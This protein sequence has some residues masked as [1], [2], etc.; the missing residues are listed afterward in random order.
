[1]AGGR[2]RRRVVPLNMGSWRA[3][4]GRFWARPRACLW[5]PGLRRA[6]S[7]RPAVAAAT[8]TS[9]LRQDPS[10]RSSAR[11]ARKCRPCRLLSGPR[12]AGPVRS[13]V[14]RRRE[15]SRPTGRQRVTAIVQPCTSPPSR[16]S[17]IPRAGCWSSRTCAL[18]SG[19]SSPDPSRARANQ[20]QA[21]RDLAEAQRRRH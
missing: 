18:T 1:M 8:R 4:L 15:L 10:S 19:N 20:G 21:A 7:L 5:A 9:Y 6:C 13:S 12:R 3:Q 17:F 14:G 2:R 11:A 16:P